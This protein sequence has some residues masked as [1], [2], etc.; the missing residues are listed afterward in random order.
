MRL[1][2]VI[3]N[4]MLDINLRKVADVINDEIEELED[5]DKPMIYGGSL[6]STR[7]DTYYQDSFPPMS[8][9]VYLG[10]HDRQG[11]NGQSNQKIS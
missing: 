5:D 9:S 6:E 8:G 3:F 4:R 11:G 1:I 10:F 7:L 2:L